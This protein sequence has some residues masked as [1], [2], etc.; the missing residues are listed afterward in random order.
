[1]DEA[2]EIPAEAGFAERIANRIDTY[3][4]AVSDIPP[5][6]CFDRFRTSLYLLSTFRTLNM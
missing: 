1:M 2:V 4:E 3:S 5:D 6:K